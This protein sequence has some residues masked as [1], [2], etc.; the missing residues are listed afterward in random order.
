MNTLH[1][2]KSVSRARPR[3]LRGGRSLDKNKRAQ[4]ATPKP[5][6]RRWP[7]AHKQQTSTG[8][9]GGPQKVAHLSGP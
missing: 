4:E 2:V 1:T 9:N 6:C 8:L 5:R 7:A 3:S